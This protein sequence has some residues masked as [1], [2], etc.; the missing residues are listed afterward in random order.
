MRLYRNVEEHSTAG[1]ILLEGYFT[2]RIRALTLVEHGHSV[3]VLE[4]RA[5]LG[6]RA[7]TLR[8]G[9]DGHSAE[10]CGVFI[11]GVRDRWRWYARHLG[12]GRCV[13]MKLGTNNTCPD[14]GA[15]ASRRG[16]GGSRPESVEQPGWTAKRERS[17]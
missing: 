11:G 3:Q 8:H 2:V 13:M 17:A 16:Q 6:G 15:V 9:I 14:G 5:R 12:L 7:H 1:G 4:A 10:A